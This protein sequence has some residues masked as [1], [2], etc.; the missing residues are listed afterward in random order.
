MALLED[1][2]SSEGMFLELG[3]AGY[4]QIRFRWVDFKK[5][6]FPIPPTWALEHPDT[7]QIEGGMPGLQVRLHP[8]EKIPSPTVLLGFYSG[9][10]RQGSNRLRRLKLEHFGP[11]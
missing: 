9:G 8:G 11:A 4:W 2:D 7:L 10:I 1:E 5:L 6:P 3:W